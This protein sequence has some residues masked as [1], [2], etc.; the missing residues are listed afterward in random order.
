M[1]CCR[2]NGLWLKQQGFTLVELMVAIVIGLIISVGAIQ[3]FLVS[4]SSFDR[5]SAL[6]DRQETLR[7]VFDVISLDIRTASG[8]SAGA[9]V[10][11]LSFGSGV[12]P[13]D[14]Y[15]SPGELSVVEYSLSGS[16]LD[17]DYACDGGGVDGS[18]KQPLVGGLESFSPSELPT[19]VAI[20]ILFP[21]IPGESEELRTFSFQVTNRESVMAGL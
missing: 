5:V 6:A 13:D 8:Y 20:E 21:E 14:P 7:F 10:L 18:N 19:G 2:E 15:C 11:T 16:D 17:V 9:S 1:S 4:K 12:R 3:L